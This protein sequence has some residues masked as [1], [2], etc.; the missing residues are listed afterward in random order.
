[1]VPEVSNNRVLF[2]YLREDDLCLTAEP[3]PV[4]LLLPETLDVQASCEYVPVFTPVSG[5]HQIRSNQQ[6]CARLS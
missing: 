6:K 3:I 2:E 4:A 1:M 5:R